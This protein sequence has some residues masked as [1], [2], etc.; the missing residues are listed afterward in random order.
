MQMSSGK[1]VTIRAKRQHLR[2]GQERIG[3]LFVSFRVQNCARKPLQN[4][5]SASIAGIW[6]RTPRVGGRLMAKHVFH[7]AIGVIGVGDEDLK[8][9]LVDGVRKVIP[10]GVRQQEVAA[11]E[12]N[13][14]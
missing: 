12:N 11:S 3:A 13:G 14:R 8:G 2:P 7:F 1:R 10:S 5:E 4:W 6:G 9:P